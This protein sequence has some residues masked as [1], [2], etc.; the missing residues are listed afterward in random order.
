MANTNGSETATSFADEP[1]IYH[2]LME[3]LKEQQANRRSL[4]DL[5]KKAIST[6][7]TLPPT[8]PG[9]GDS[10]WVG[11]LNSFSQ[12]CGAIIDF[13]ADS[14]NDF[15]GNPR[16]TCVCEVKLS[17]SSGLLTFPRAEDSPPEERANGA[18]T[19]PT[20]TRRKDA[21]QYAAKCAAEYLMREGLIVFTET[22][23]PKFPGTKKTKAGR[24]SGKNNGSTTNNNDKNVAAKKPADDGPHV[25]KRVEELCHKLGLSFP[26]YRISP[27]ADQSTTTNYGME[28]VTPAGE[29]PNQQFF[30]AH[31]EWP[32]RDALKVPRGLGR[33]TRVYGRRNARERVAEQVLEWLVEEEGRRMREVEELMAAMDGATGV[34]GAG[35]GTGATKGQVVVVEAG[36]A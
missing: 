20:F 17:P 16:H 10:N 11:L 6:L 8:E 36:S 22:G 27:S 1:L 30:D 34:A 12:S 35:A 14:E 9:I 29:S 2:N 24:S 5:Q 25:T 23:A 33:V 18:W 21:K 31:A 3:W 26:Q 32:P 7:L 19:L 28:G 15:G 13:K 4:S